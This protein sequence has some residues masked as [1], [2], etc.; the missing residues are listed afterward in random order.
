MK[1]F[2]RS[3]KQS[4]FLHCVIEILPMP[5]NLVRNTL[6][7]ITAKQGHISITVV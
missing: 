1:P 2:F 6:L 4:E 3:F 5:S 7:V